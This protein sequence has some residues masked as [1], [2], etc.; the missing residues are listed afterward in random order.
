MARNITS[1]R[2]ASHRTSK[3]FVASGHVSAQVRS[4]RGEKTLSIDPSHVNCPPKCDEIHE[5]SPVPT[6][7]TSSST[8]TPNTH[9]APL[10]IQQMTTEESEPDELGHSQPHTTILDLQSDSATS[11]ALPENFGFTI[12]RDGKL[13][14]VYGSKNVWLVYTEQ[15]PRAFMR[16][17][18]VRRKPVAIDVLDDGSL[19]AV[20]TNPTKLDIYSLREGD[21]TIVKRRKTVYLANDSTCLAL[22]PNGLVLAVGSRNGIEIISLAA[23]DSEPDKRIMT[24]DPM[25]SLYFSDDSR[26]L[27]A[28]T[29]VRH[30]KSTTIFTVHGSFDGPFTEEGEPILL[31]VDKAWTSQVL[32]PEKAKRARQAT[33]VPDATTAQVNELFAYDADKHTWGIYDVISS[34]FKEFKTFLPDAP[35]SIKPG[36]VEAAMPAVS[37]L[38]DHVAIAVRQDRCAEIWLYRLPESQGGDLEYL[39]DINHSEQESPQEPCLKVRLPRDE[40]SRSQEIASLRWLKISGPG[41]AERLIAVGS[42][43]IASSPDGSIPDI[44]QSSSGAIVIIDFDRETLAGPVEAVPKRIVFDLDTLMPG[45][46]LPDEDIDFDREVEIVRRRTVAQKAAQDRAAARRLSRQLGRS[47]TTAS[48][49]S[50]RRASNIPTGSTDEDQLGGDEAVAAFEQPYDHSQPRSQ[51]S[52]NRAATVAATA[53]AARNRLRALPDRPLEYRRADGLREIPHES[54]ADNWVPPPP[55]YTPRAEPESVSL[56]YP[57]T[58]GPP[59]SAMPA[60]LPPPSAMPA[61]LPHPSQGS[62]VTQAGRIRSSNT[63]PGVPTLSIPRPRSSRRS[64]NHDV[65]RQG[66]PI[67]APPVPPLPT[68][69]SAVLPRGPPVVSANSQPRR[70][71]TLPS[72]AE[73]VALPAPVINVSPALTQRNQTEADRLGAGIAAPTP[74]RVIRRAVGD[75]PMEPP[76]AASAQVSTLGVADL[77]RV[78]QQQG[79]P[80]VLP[81]TTPTSNRMLPRSRPLIPGTSQYPPPVGMMRNANT[82][83][84]PSTMASSMSMPQNPFQQRNYPQPQ[85]SLYAHTQPQH[86][87]THANAQSQPYPSRPPIPTQQ[88]AYLETS[89]SIPRHPVGARHS[90]S[91]SHRSSISQFYLSGRRAQSTEALAAPR[92]ASA[93]EP[94]RQED[95]P[96]PPSSRRPLLSR[97]NT[98]GSF[99]R[100]LGGGNPG[101]GNLD[102]RLVPG[103]VHDGPMVSA[104]PFTGNMDP[105]QD[106]AAQRSLDGQGASERKPTK[107][108]R[109]KCV[110]M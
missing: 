93:M 73:N 95:F 56:T 10:S 67:D 100:S 40:E 81:S 18:E 35:K 96:H 42:N 74:V 57:R 34:S 9:A 50:D 20:L 21:D 32:F 16:I 24:S 51:A 61:S 104:P 47:S 94:R 7:G 27:L 49:D 83:G 102:A 29:V 80:P 64:Q 36:L 89:A 19:L 92:S 28:T 2:D 103:R 14:A 82:P 55:P 6:Q 101:S 3:D 78:Q 12:S 46:R 106:L 38:A 63:F 108:E 88:S 15:L 62:R 84:R 105:W 37:P 31:D 98:S 58:G 48:R 77:I 60:V 85:Q 86:S 33:L 110:M 69:F 17:F 68:S 76:Q 25:D 22:A 70:S 11:S 4:G 79:V 1:P 30:R 99:G 109:V 41:G 5:T 45:E 44:S 53:P 66:A 52:L 65:S 97:L 107:V 59:T 8:T 71:S 91:S 26:T 23:A 87:L 43:V 72:P 54:D 13:V 39:N 75:E 90:R